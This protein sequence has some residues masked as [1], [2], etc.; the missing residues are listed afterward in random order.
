MNRRFE[1]Y[2][3]YLSG[4]RNLSRNTVESYRRDLALLDHWVASGGSLPGSA[5]DPDALRLSVGELRFFVSDLG[6]QGYESSSLN[7]ILASVRGFFRYAVHFGLRADNPASA[8]RNLKVPK[9]LPEFLFADE[10]E[11]LC[12]LPAALVEKAPRKGSKDSG[13]TIHSL[14]PARDRALLTALYT[15]GCRVSEIAGLAMRDLERDLSA[16]VVR[17][18]GDKE[19]R[20]FFAKDARKALAEYI[21]E[22][23]ALLARMQENNAAKAAL[24]LSSRGNPLSVRGIQFI[25]A[26]YTDTT[27]GMRHLSPHALRHSFATTMITR[28][29]DIRVV[30][31][32]LGHSSI[33]TTQRYTH[34]TGEGLKRLYH[35]A[36]PHG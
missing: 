22:R 2:L 15:S 16:A 14:W 17:G 30:Q 11:R 8:I 24:F 9:K 29:A 31:E 6:A 10:A 3:E 12:A 20:V 36:H 27:E 21:P 4:V 28:G 1:E 19:R 18:K 26:H 23:A 13:A 33:S 5:C 7:R 35:R 25:L 32:L 34:V